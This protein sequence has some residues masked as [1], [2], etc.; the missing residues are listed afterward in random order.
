M[1]FL[2]LS[3]ILVVVTRAEIK[4]GAQEKFLDGLASILRTEKETVTFT[5]QETTTTTF[6]ETLRQTTTTIDYRTKTLT[7]TTIDTVTHWISFSTDVTRLTTV[8]ETKM[9]T[10]VDEQTVRTLTTEIQNEDVVINL[11]MLTSELPTRTLVTTA[12]VTETSVATVSNVRTNVVTLLNQS[13][14]VSSTEL[15]ERQTVWETVT[16]SLTTQVEE[17]IRTPR[18]RTV[19]KTRFVGGETTI[20][21]PPATTPTAVSWQVQLR[22]QQRRRH[23]RPRK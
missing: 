4:D 21:V 1:K 6:T 13:T 8:T 3:W 19:T 20:T 11:R 2:W 23:G 17:R 5:E 12:W 16:L 10:R 22:P 15:V 14:A 7:S 18:I 9:S